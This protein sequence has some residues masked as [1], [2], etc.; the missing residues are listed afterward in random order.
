MLWAF[1]SILAMAPTNTR[2]LQQPHWR[3]NQTQVKVVKIQHVSKRKETVT[4][5]RSAIKQVASG[6]FGVT[7]Y[8]LS[9][10]DELQIKMAWLCE[11]QGEGG[12]LPGDKVDDWIGV[13]RHQFRRGPAS[14]RHTTIFITSI[15]AWSTI[16]KTRNRKCMCQREA[17]IRSW[18]RYDCIRC[19]KSESWRSTYRRFW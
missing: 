5:K 19:S 14:E 4:G 2:L 10:A 7:S 9:N 3:E 8:Y 12:Q 16:W 6:R 1:G 11:T 15:A 18:R 13:T 17:S